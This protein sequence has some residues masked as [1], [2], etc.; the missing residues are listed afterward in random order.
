M[1]LGYFVYTTV[2]GTTYFFG[3]NAIFSSLDGTTWELCVSSPMP[4]GNGYIGY[5]VTYGNKIY[6]TGG[7]LNGHMWSASINDL[8]TWTQEADSPVS[9]GITTVTNSG[10]IVYKNKLW[11]IGVFNKVY[12]FDGAV[13]TL[14]GTLPASIDAQYPG[15]GIVIWNEKIWG[16]GGLKGNNVGTG[17]NQIWN[18]DGTTFEVVGNL[19]TALIMQNTLV[20][21]NGQLYSIGGVKPIAALM[22]HITWS[23]IINI[24]ISGM[25]ILYNKAIPQSPS[26]DFSQFY[27]FGESSDPVT[28][29][30]DP[31]KTL[32]MGKK[33]S[34]ERPIQPSEWITVASGLYKYTIDNSTDENMYGNIDTTSIM[35]GN[36][37]IPNRA[38]AYAGTYPV[39]EIDSYTN[40]QDYGKISIYNNSASFLEVTYDAYQPIQPSSIGVASPSGTWVY[41]SENI[42]NEIPSDVF[43]TFPTTATVSGWASYEGE[44]SDI[45]TATISVGLRA[46]QKGILRLDQRF[47]DYFSYL[48]MF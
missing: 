9:N 38:S 20:V 7:S 37:P 41:Y 21:S 26:N 24:Y 27:T 1:E 25:K 12:F 43:I 16:L 2:N 8:S 33:F 42:I 15:R 46:D 28:G 45:Q 44:T 32:V 10:M 35:Y 22:A 36:T 34:T 40:P 23:P 39:Y 14:F 6:V 29:Y 18:F 13:W 11:C 4:W 48:R 30:T 31:V 19:P 5:A 47:P 3:P 17:T